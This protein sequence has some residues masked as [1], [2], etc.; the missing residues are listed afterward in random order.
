MDSIVDRTLRYRVPAWWWA[1]RAA[2][3]VC[4]AYLA[5][6]WSILSREFMR[7]AREIPSVDARHEWLM[8]LQLGLAAAVLTVYAVLFAYQA[9]REALEAKRAWVRLGSGRLVMADWRGRE[10]ALDLNEISKVRVSTYGGLCRTRPI[11]SLTTARGPVTLSPW[12][13]E[14][15]ALVEQVVSQAGLKPAA[16]NWLRTIYA[17][18]GS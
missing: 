10:K 17:R 7:F 2:I 11:I 18:Q 1:L 16:E 3:I 13:E 4:S 6:C 12:I 5:G 14:R 15:S 9:L 8:A